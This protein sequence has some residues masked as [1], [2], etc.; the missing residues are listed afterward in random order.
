[1]STGTTKFLRAHFADVLSTQSLPNEI[2][3]EIID[4]VAT[5]LHTI[6]SLIYVRPFQ[7]HAHRILYRGLG[8]SLS[9][10]SQRCD[11]RISLLYRTLSE[12]PM[13]GEY[14]RAIQ[15]LRDPVEQDGRLRW[16]RLSEHSSGCYLGELMTSA[17]SKEDHFERDAVFQAPLD[18][19]EFDGSEMHN[20]P[21]QDS[22]CIP[23]ELHWPNYGLNEEDMITQW[24]RK[25]SW[26]DP[27]HTETI[28][29][30]GILR[31]TPNVQTYELGQMR[32][33]RV[34]PNWSKFKH[35]LRSALVEALRG[36]S[37]QSVHIAG[38]LNI[39]SFVFAATPAVYVR[40]GNGAF[41]V[42]R[43][44]A[45]TVKSLARSANTPIRFLSLGDIAWSCQ[46]PFL[47]MVTHRKVGRIDLAPTS[48]AAFEALN[49]ACIALQDSI[50]CLVVDLRQLARTMIEN[51]WKPHMQG[52]LN[53]KC[54]HQ[55]KT[56]HLIFTDW[57][58]GIENNGFTMMVSDSWWWWAIDALRSA[59]HRPGYGSLRNIIL[60]INYQNMMHL[61]HLMNWDDWIWAALQK[62]LVD[63]VKSGVRRV[64]VH[65]QSAARYPTSEFPEDQ[66]LRILLKAQKRLESVGGLEVSHHATGNLVVRL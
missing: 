59:L 19:I 66:R 35:P 48:P 18:P 37:L 61:E 36:K 38:L 52:R 14:V 41:V 27:D 42:Q 6:L 8:L 3:K 39:P 46:P 20:T 40:A 17:L 4:Y 30:P 60:T 50:T 47:K 45:R 7:P 57:K 13:L 15:I 31:L 33:S 26:H 24:E 49:D 22:N 56:V 25:V 54:L 11:R 5:D 1:M 9:V 53:L 62:V 43:G 16:G 64:W 63:Q 23:L 10:D 29:L 2:W 58:L 51:S 44:T 12:R 21:A 28:H 34:H 55:L 65:L 32:V